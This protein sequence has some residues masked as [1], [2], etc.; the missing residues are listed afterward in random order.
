MALKSVRIENARSARNTRCG[1]KSPI[2]A[3]NGKPK[4]TG[5]IIAKT[6]IVN[7]K[8]IG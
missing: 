6:G 7:S 3:L 4:N 1:M 2:G 8:F 5:R